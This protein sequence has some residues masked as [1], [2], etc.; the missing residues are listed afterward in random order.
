MCAC[1]DVRHRKS[2]HLK[3]AGVCAEVSLI[4]HYTLFTCLHPEGHQEGKPRE[5]LRHHSE[6]SINLLEPLQPKMSFRNTY[7]GWLTFALKTDVCAVIRKMTSHS[8]IT[9]GLEANH[10]L[11]YNMQIAYIIETW[12]HFRDMTFE[13]G[14]SFIDLFKQT[15]LHIHIVCNL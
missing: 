7:F 1:Q 10:V 11:N 2:F 4:Q 14:D 6:E 3:N 9:T 5:H 8:N 12:Q 13:A 15:I